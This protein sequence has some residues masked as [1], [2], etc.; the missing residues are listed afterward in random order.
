MENMDRN[1]KIEA[2]TQKIGAE[3]GTGDQLKRAAALTPAV[4]SAIKHLSD[5]DIA[6]ISAILN[7]KDATRRILATP[8]AQAILKKLKEQ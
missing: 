2:L 3:T 4:A 5:N 7:D 1:A 6:R 8:Q